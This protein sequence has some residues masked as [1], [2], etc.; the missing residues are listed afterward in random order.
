[1]TEFGVGSRVQ[2]VRHVDDSATRLTIGMT[3]TVVYRFSPAGW[4]GV[5][6]DGLSNGHN[7][8]GAAPDGTGWNVSAD[9]IAH[10]DPNPLVVVGGRALGDYND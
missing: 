5:S 10:Y 4:L 2:L 6:W 8:A 9:A 1:M 3:G 7:S